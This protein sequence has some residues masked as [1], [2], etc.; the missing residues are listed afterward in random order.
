M[1][2]ARSRYSDGAVS[3][4]LSSLRHSLRAQLWPLPALGVF[5]AVAAGVLFPRVDTHIDGGLPRWLDDL[6]FGGDPGAARALLDSVSSSL[7]TVTS[8]TF[9]LTVVTLQLASSQFSPRLLPT[10]TR[11]LFVQA[12]LA[13][14]LATFVYALTVLRSVHSTSG[15]GAAFVPHLSVTLALVLAVLSVLALVLF[16]AHLA[17]QIRVE[18][19][20]RT[21]ARR[22]LGHRA[23]HAGTR[24]V[25]QTVSAGSSGGAYDA[26]RGRGGGHRGS[27]SVRL[28]RECRGAGT[29]AGRG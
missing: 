19:M 18:T 27:S 15:T 10:F 8:L 22:R 23:Q 26:D 29:V 9:S 11:D 25:G 20:L 13:L 12:T 14:F 16:L 4:W 21:G 24:R 28:A 2:T 7:I 5:A 6:L 3:G 17:R 1:P